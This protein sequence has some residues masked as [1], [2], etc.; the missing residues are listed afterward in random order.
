MLAL[1]EARQVG[2]DV[3]KTTWQ[4]ALRHWVETQNDDGSWSYQTGSKQAPGTGSMT[5]SGIASIAI[6]SAQLDGEDDLTGPGKQSIARAADWLGR[7]FSVERNPGVDTWQFYYL[8]TLERA[9]RMAGV[10]R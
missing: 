3:S 1:H 9:G 7:N 10:G 5:C 8:H 2:I 4:A 6:A